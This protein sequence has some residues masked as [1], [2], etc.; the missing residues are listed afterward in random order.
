[1]LLVA[2]VIAVLG[3]GFSTSLGAAYGIAVTGTMLITTLL[4]FFVV[5]YA[6]HYNWPV[7]LLATGYFFAI[8]AAFFSANLL[9]S[10]QGGW[11]PLL[12]GGVVF[13][14]VSA[15]KGGR[16]LLAAQATKRAGSVPPHGYLANLFNKEPVRVP[17]SA[18]FL[19]TDPV[20]VPHA[21]ARSLDHFGVV[22]EHIIFAKVTTR[23]V[24]YVSSSDRIQLESI[25]WNCYRLTVTYGF[26]DEV[27]L[28]EALGL[29]ASSGLA[30]DPLKV[31]YF[32]SH[33]LIVATPGS[34]M[35]LWREKLFVTMSQNIGHL[36]AHLQLPANQVV[37]LGTRV[38]I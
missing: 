15:W 26:K 37:E 5:R 25:G 12:I 13:T 3:F 27:N 18:V 2:V 14:L 30:L 22:H 33:A 35:W 4:T 1:M 8:D 16:E 28:P 7:C 21:F 24:P 34:G 10:V 9:K 19:T 36:A 17:A 23:E 38:E 6:W 20:G 31:S 29:S 11:F 32:L